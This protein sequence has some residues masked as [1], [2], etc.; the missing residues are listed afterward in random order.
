MRTSPFDTAWNRADS[1]FS[2]RPSSSNAEIN[3]LGFLLYF[4]GCDYHPKEEICQKGVMTRPGRHGRNER[5]PFIRQVLQ[6]AREPIKTIY[7]LTFNML[8]DIVKYSLSN[9]H[10][11]YY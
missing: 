7:R 3:L 8:Y 4:F 10:M 2:L 9:F 6:V 11:I 5:T 1:S